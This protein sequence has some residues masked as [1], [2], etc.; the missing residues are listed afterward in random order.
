MSANDSDFLQRFTLEQVAVRGQLV[1]LSASLHEA[2]AQHSYSHATQ[3][4]LKQFFAAATLLSSTI[5]FKGSLSLQAK[6]EGHITLIMAECNQ[7]GEFRG[8]A[9]ENAAQSNDLNFSQLLAKGTLAITINPEDGQRYQGIVPLEGDSLA[10]CLSLYFMQSEQLK[11]Y[12]KFADDADSTAALM[13][14]VLPATPLEADDWDTAITLA[15][16]VT[17]QELNNTDSEHL[18]YQLFNSLGVRAFESQQLQF[19]CSCSEQRGLAAINAL[20]VDD[21]N[22]L[23]AENGEICIDC[24]F[25]GCKY[26][27]GQLELTKLFS[28]AG[29][30][31][32]H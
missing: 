8:I 23:L 13:L 12:F 15:D 21:A 6:S 17:A 10:D 16:T 29:A 14:Q 24:E 26:R 25:C 2:M 7:N 9:Q 27:Y 11:T 5:K 20:G 31:R 30:S 18:L 19:A 3:S 32:S 22:A 4:L 1:R 28:N